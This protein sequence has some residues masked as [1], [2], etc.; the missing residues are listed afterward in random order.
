MLTRETAL[1]RLRTT[2][3]LSTSARSRTAVTSEQA[4]DPVALAVARIV[5]A[6]RAATAARCLAPSVNH[7]VLP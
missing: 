1:Q 5:A 4:R 2:G 6:N 7:L 3:T